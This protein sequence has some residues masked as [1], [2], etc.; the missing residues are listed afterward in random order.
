MTMISD[1]FQKA[2]TRLEE[3]L[4]Q[5]KDEFIRDSVIQRFEFCVE[6]AWKTTK[7]VMGTPTSPPK[8]VVREM[9]K[10]GYIQDVDMWLLSIDM[11][12]LTSHTYQEPL[13]EKV[14]DFAKAFLPHLKKLREKLLKK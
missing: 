5:P 4:D 6:L 7:K 12:N 10:G 13:A 8:D 9:A 14:Y 2:V 1:E 11:R 3:A